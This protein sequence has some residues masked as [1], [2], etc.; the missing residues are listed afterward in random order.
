[1]GSNCLKIIVLLSASFSFGALSNDEAISQAI[2]QVKK[3]MTERQARI[4]DSFASIQN[5]RLKKEDFVLDK[6]PHK[7]VSIQGVPLKCLS[8][9][10]FWLGKQDGYEYEDCIYHVDI[11]S[12]ADIKS[13][14]VTLSQRTVDGWEIDRT[15]L[16]SQESKNPSKTVNKE[17]YRFKRKI[18]E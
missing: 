3:I 5:S 13:M 4:A 16:S 8:T 15:E 10:F 14:M 12:D 1:M 6:L 9:N 11:Q 18:K 2:M 7:G 17:K